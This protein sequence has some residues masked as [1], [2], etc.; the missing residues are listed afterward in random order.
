MED[1]GS[2][3]YSS[4]ET[5]VVGEGTSSP[6]P[7]AKDYMSDNQDDRTRGRQQ[8]YSYKLEDVATP[9]F[10]EDARQSRAAAFAISDVSSDEADAHVIPTN[11]RGR[12]RSS[13]NSRDRSHSLPPVLH[14]RSSRHAKSYWDESEDDDRSLQ[15]SVSSALYRYEM[16]TTW[17][18]EKSLRSPLHYIEPYFSDSGS[19]TDSSGGHSIRSSA[20]RL[21]RKARKRRLSLQQ[22]GDTTSRP[23]TSANVVSTGIG[24]VRSLISES[25]EINTASSVVGSTEERLEKE[26][27]MIYDRSII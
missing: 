2:G 6:S 12:P 11:R 17:S 16:P 25:T 3:Y 7:E 21:A 23:G 18:K 15:G 19:N 8:H 10:Q 13:T 20:S 26:P 1:A 5:N 22:M 4:P 24:R 9:S 14:E 27:V